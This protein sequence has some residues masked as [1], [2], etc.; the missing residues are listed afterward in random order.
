MVALGNQGLNTSGELDCW[1]ILVVRGSG[2]VGFIE[3]RTGCG[4][5]GKGW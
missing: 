4:G 2:I 5:L 1:L 3:P